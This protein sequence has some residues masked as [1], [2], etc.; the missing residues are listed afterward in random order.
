MHIFSMALL[1]TVLK[2]SEMKQCCLLVITVLV[3]MVSLTTPFAQEDFLATD[4]VRKHAE[5][6]VHLFNKANEICGSSADHTSEAKAAVFKMW[7]KTEIISQLKSP[8]ELDK[9]C[10]GCMASA[11]ERWL[12]RGCSC[13]ESLQTVLAFDGCVYGV[14]GKKNLDK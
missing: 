6:M 7:V 8:S 10:I 13:S 2:G 3:L 14:L 4:D 1:R 9:I 12:K 11:L 5:V